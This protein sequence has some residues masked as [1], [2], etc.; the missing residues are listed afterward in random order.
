MPGSKSTSPSS[1]PRRK[2]NGSTSQ[3][4]GSPPKS[5]SSNGPSPHHSQGSSSSEG[6]TPVHSAMVNGEACE[7]NTPI[8]P[9]RRKRKSTRKRNVLPSK[10]SESSLD[11]LSPDESSVSG[12]SSL[13]GGQRSPDESHS[14]LHDQAASVSTSDR[15]HDLTSDTTSRSPDPFSEE[16]LFS[17][18]SVDCFDSS[19]EVTRQL[20]LTNGDP[21]TS[22]SGVGSVSDAP[23]SRT[24]LMAMVDSSS[25][26]GGQRPYSVLVSPYDINAQFNFPDESTSRLSGLV[27]MPRGQAQ[28]WS[29]RTQLLSKRQS[30]RSAQLPYS[31]MLMCTWQL[32]EML[33]CTALIKAWHNVLLLSL[34][35]YPHPH[36][37]L[38]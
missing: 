6:P 35:L 32:S 8:P 3:S 22:L 16:D 2:T 36:F 27:T 38:Y 30:Q 26:G 37:L 4:H 5:S 18:D 29:P 7:E 10:D 34:P 23:S 21:S 31:S 33:S 17:H 15:S 28:T 24:S 25:S 13:T 12:S 19:A 14:L 1:K 20:K 9:P 11:V